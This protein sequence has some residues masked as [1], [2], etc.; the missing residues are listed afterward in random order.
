MDITD[1]NILWGEKKKK[2]KHK[3]YYTQTTSQLDLKG[4]TVSFDKR[5][6]VSGGAGFIG[7]HFLCYMVKKYP[8]FHFTCIDKLNYASNATEIENLKSFSNFEFVHL[9]L[10]DNLEYLLKITKN[11]TDII[12]FAAESSV[13]RSFK[14]PVYFTKNNILATQNLLECHRLNPSIGY[15][16]HIS[17][18]EVYGDV[19]EGDNKEN[20]VMNPT[21]PYSASKAAIDLI[22]KSYQYSYKL[23]ITILRPNNVY[24]PLQYPEKIIPLTIQCINEKKPIPVHGKGTNKRKYLYVLDIVLAIETVWIKNPMT[25][26]NQIYNIG[27]TDELDNLSLI[28]LI[29]EIFGRGE[30]QFIKDRN[31]NDT[32]YSIDTTKIHNLGWS[33]KISLVQGLQLCKQLLDSPIE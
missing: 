22:I 31:Y 26:V 2:H 18:D 6:V 14:D 7:I 4:M 9:D 13:D 21:N 11:T 5:I 10:S 30:I 29:M 3:L 27:G 19:Y 17:T 28:K 25:T 32:N 23:P 33:P 8:N 1:K 20:A 16:L 15:F 12:N 24:G